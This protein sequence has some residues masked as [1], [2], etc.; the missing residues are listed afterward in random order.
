MYVCDIFDR[1]VYG[2][3]SDVET[4]DVGRNETVSWDVAYYGFRPPDAAEAI[5]IDYAYGTITGTT[6]TRTES[7]FIITVI[8]VLVGLLAL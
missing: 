1:T 8:G 6:L 7:G 3:F 4:C 2:K 5:W